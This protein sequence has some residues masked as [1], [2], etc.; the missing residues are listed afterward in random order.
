LDAR[1]PGARA[2]A[3]DPLPEVAWA[4][5]AEVPNFE[6]P[7]PAPPVLRTWVPQQGWGKV[8]EWS[9]PDPVDNVLVRA[10][11]GV[12]FTLA[13]TLIILKLAVPSEVGYYWVPVILFDFAVRTLFGFRLSPFAWLANAALKVGRIDVLLVPSKAKRFSFFLGCVLN[14]VIL[15]LHFGL[16]THFKTGPTIALAVFSGLESI[17]GFCVGCWFFQTFFAMRDRWH[18]RRDYMRMGGELRARFMHDVDPPLPQNISIQ[19]GLRDSAE[20]EVHRF[21]YD[22]IVI[23]GGSGGLAAAKEAARL[24]RKVALL[25]FVK[26]SP[27]GSVWGIGGTCVNVGCIPKKL[28]HQ[29]AIIGKIVRGHAQAFGWSEGEG[30]ESRP[31]VQFNWPRL[32]ANILEHIHSLNNGYLGGL[33]SAKVLYI[34][35]MGKLKDA[36]TVECTPAT[37][38]K[39]AITGRRILIAVGG[40]PSVPNIPGAEL[41]ITSDDVFFLEQH[42][43]QTLLVGA[44]YIALELASFLQGLGCDTTVF[45]R[46]EPLR[47]FD[48]DMAKRVVDSVALAGTRFV[49]GVSPT[50]MARQADGRISVAYTE[51]GGEAKT[52]TFDTVVFA[53][54]REVQT[55]GLGLAEAGVQTD[56]VGRIYHRNERTTTPNIYAVGDVLANGLELTP[57]AIQAGVL[58]MQRLYDGRKE[59]MSYAL[60]PTVVFTT[61]EYGAC[62]MS[63]ELAVE[64]FGEKNI[65]VFHAEFTP[66]EW[67]VPH[68]KFQC[69]VKVIAN[70]L[71]RGRVVGVHYLGPNAGE[72]L[73]GFA[74]AMRCGIT[75]AELDSVTGIHP[76]CAEE[77][78]TL[79]RTKRSGAV[80]RKT[81]C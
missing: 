60:V 40:R 71:D 61:P 8:P 15:I 64:V 48:K 55:A 21:D 66:L 43:G 29:A 52:M 62:G 23:G 78:V 11:S 19:G 28:C 79:R 13:L 22:L 51:K 74:A 73:Q 80:F 37:D 69:Y 54:G 4:W 31:G 34:N 6:F 44:S 70:Y 35:A 5:P 10:T 16:D 41:G 50:S 7:T 9:F 46:S 76:V 57:V 77:V 25:D 42:P 58:L 68:C 26:P 32:R 53:I 56:K 30:G 39:F 45:V 72:V 38:P 63:E 65:E 20:P 67:T 33:R 12:V 24:G 59:K 2:M 49:L 18:T 17:G 47:G 3:V 36:H 75:K 14:T 27:K 81:G 1:Q